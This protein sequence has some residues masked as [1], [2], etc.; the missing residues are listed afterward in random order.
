MATVLVFLH[1]S[2]HTCG[3]GKHPEVQSNRSLLES[4][5]KVHGLEASQILVELK[6]LT[7]ERLVGDSQSGDSQSACSLTYESTSWELWS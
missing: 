6:S 7:S 4:D 5:P 2:V 3:A 1:N